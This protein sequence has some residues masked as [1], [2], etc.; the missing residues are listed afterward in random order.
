MLFSMRGAASMMRM[1]QCFI[2]VAT[3]APTVATDAPGH[4]DIREGMRHN[5][6]SSLKT[7][8]HKLFVRFQWI[9]AVDCYKV[10]MCGKRL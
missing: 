8:L 10:G 2:S 1:R 5:M 3:H 7:A 4:M 6:V 9:A